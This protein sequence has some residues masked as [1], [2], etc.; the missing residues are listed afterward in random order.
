MMDYFILVILRAGLSF[1]C[2]IKQK[3]QKM[4]KPTNKE[5]CAFYFYLRQRSLMNIYVN[6]EISGRK[7]ALVIKILFSTSSRTTKTIWK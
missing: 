1:P 2:C 5:V 3:K 7:Q 4:F 6:V